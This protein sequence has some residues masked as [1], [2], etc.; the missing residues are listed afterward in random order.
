MINVNI[1]YIY[2]NANKMVNFLKSLNMDIYD[3]IY[4][5]CANDKKIDKNNFIEYKWLNFIDE[6][7]DLNS[8]KKE[9]LHIVNDDII[10][11]PDY[12]FFLEDITNSYN[13]NLYINVIYDILNENKKIVSKNLYTN[14][15]GNNNQKIKYKNFHDDI[16]TIIFLT[17]NLC[18]KYR[19]IGKFIENIDNEIKEILSEE[20]FIYLKD[21][22]FVE[23]KLN[24]K[25]LNSNDFIEMNHDVLLIKNKIIESD[26]VSFDVFDTL[27]YRQLYSPYDV[28]V[29]IDKLH[30]KKFKNFDS[31]YGF[32]RWQS[33]REV[34][35]FQSECSFD[36]IYN[37]LKERFNFKN[38]EIDAMQKNELLL[39]E[40]FLK[41]KDSIYWLYV[42]AKKLNKKIFIISDMYLEKNRLI[43]IL[44]KFNITVP[45]ECIYVSN[46]KRYSKHNSK[47]YDFLRRKNPNNK[48]VHIGDNF[49]SDYL[50]SLKYDIDAIHLK[51]SLDIW[52]E[53]N[54]KCIND[55]LY[56]NEWYR[57]ALGFLI[58]KFFNN[59]FIKI[60]KE[61]FLSSENFFTFFVFFPLA[62]SVWMFVNKKIVKNKINNLFLIGR[63]G[64][65]INEIL[66]IYKT[67][68]KN[69]HSLNN[70]YLPFSRKIYYQYSFFSNDKY[71][72]NFLTF[73]KYNKNFYK[74]FGI[75][76]NDF[77][78]RDFLKNFLSL[79]S[80]EYE[81]IFDERCLNKKV[82]NYETFNEIRSKLLDNI[83]KEI[84]LEKTK[85]IEKYY[86]NYFD[87]NNQH[88]ND[89]IFE[90]SS[91][92]NERIFFSFLKK[93]FSSIYIMKKNENSILYNNI[94]DKESFHFLD[95]NPHIKWEFFEMLFSSPDVGTLKKINNDLTL[96]FS[97]IKDV[98]SN[99]LIKKIQKN[100][101]NMFKDFFVIFHDIIDFFDFNLS[102]YFK[103]EWFLNNEH[104]VFNNNVTKNIFIEDSL[105]DVYNQKLTDSVSEKKIS[106]SNDYYVLNFKKIGLKI[107]FSKNKI[108]WKF[109]SKIYLRFFNK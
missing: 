1:I 29:L 109:L 94:F 100:T 92:S 82:E 65:L 21:V 97:P 96:Q 68:N 62:L 35:T 41:I 3:N 17:K 43:N 64:Y 48:W 87:L 89:Y 98:T 93:H 49:Y 36:E 59:P 107:N 54:I 84:I 20:N 42:F 2:E 66:N 74:T 12:F 16:S 25:E 6:H 63:D 104:F 81:E 8:L 39:E 40:K 77:T 102:A 57:F 78:V 22:F 50:N 28:F 44:K 53:L 51:S 18:K 75:N 9:F 27:V 37:H 15:M 83:K 55:N 58:S 26:I 45:N 38:N 69:Y 105:Y 4:I 10:F 73:N 33:Q 61:T 72:T 46:E 31:N 14:I 60:N 52:N 90:I 88:K 95:S 13:K 86:L 70:V 32:L 101:L 5:Y 19:A 80:K 11:H 91:S 56:E 103:F 85:I 67:F 7:F 99:L 30:K 71:W 76:Y 34:E 24:S 106:T 79:D 23:R 47:I 108:F